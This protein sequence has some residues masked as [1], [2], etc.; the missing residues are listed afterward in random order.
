M[1][2]PWRYWQLVRLSMQGHRQV[3]DLPI[4]RDRLTAQFPTLDDVKDI[5][6][7]RWLFEQMHQTSE[8]AQS[9]EGC[10]RCFISHAIDLTCQ[11]LYSR[12]RSQLGFAQREEMLALVLLDV[13]PLRRRPITPSLADDPTPAGKILRSFDPDKAQLSTWT[14]RLILSD[15][16]LNGYL[17]DQAFSPGT[18]LCL[19]GKTLT[20]SIEQGVCHQRWGVA[21][22]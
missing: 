8:T 13:D 6:V 9:A 18:E 21:A 3:D 12:F 1:K 20:P 5:A 11:D 10:L 22:G 16:T 4:C 17:Q 2:T 15:R 7:Q 19:V 14:K